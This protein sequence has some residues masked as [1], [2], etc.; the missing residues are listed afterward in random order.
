MNAA[1][2]ILL[3]VLAYAAVGFLFAVAF[4]CF[5]ITR[6]DGAAKDSST[7]FRALMIPGVAAL[8][9]LMLRKWRGAAAKETTHDTQ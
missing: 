6:V 8:W 1:Q 9:P 7:Y 2:I 5:G 3:L 4:V